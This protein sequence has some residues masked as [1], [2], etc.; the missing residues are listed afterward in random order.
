[1]VVKV[2]TMEDVKKGIS[3]TVIP[4]VIGGIG[5][6]I[7][8]SVAGPIGAAIGGLLAGMT[9]DDVAARIIGINAIQD[10]AFAALTG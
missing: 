10:G 6:A 3:G 2:P 7:G 9:Q 5:Q 1:M 8:Y 4:G